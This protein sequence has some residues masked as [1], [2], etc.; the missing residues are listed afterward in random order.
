MPLQIAENS[1]ILEPTNAA[2][3]KV[4]RQCLM[5]ERYWR[6]TEATECGLHELTTQAMTRSILRGR[7]G[8]GRLIFHF[9]GFGVADIVAAGK[10]AATEAVVVKLVLTLPGRKY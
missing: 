6:K 1:S 3:S 2:S 7:A 5:C 8:V 9:L 4:D 10:A